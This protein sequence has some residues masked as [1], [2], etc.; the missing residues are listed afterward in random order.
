MIEDIIESASLLDQGERTEVRGLKVGKTKRTL[1]LALSLVKGEVTRIVLRH[2]TS[3]IAVG[4]LTLP[5][6]R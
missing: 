2:A 6:G 4:K 3:A 1:T 5:H